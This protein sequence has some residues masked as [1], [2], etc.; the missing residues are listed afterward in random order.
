MT[1]KECDNCPK[2]DQ[3]YCIQKEDPECKD[4]KNEYS[5]EEI[6]QMQLADS[7]VPNA[8]DSWKKN[9]LKK[10]NQKKKNWEIIR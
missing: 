1:N 9:A 5:K 4:W 8:W 6:E 10:E 7:Y 2:W 3:G